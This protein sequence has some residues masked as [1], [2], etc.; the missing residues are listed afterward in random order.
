MNTKTFILVLLSMIIMFS[1]KN[2]GNSEFWTM[3]VIE[4][5]SAKVEG[6]ETSKGE[7]TFKETKVTDADGNNQEHWYYNRDGQLTTFERY[8]YKEG[9][10]YPYKSNFYNQRDS[11][12]SYY[13]FDYDDKGNKVRT[14]SHDGSTDELLR[15]EL[16]SYD[17]N[18]NR[19]GREIRTAGGQL[20]R[21][22][23]FKFDEDGNE[24][25]YKVFDGEGNELVAEAFKITKSDDKGW[26][27]KWSFRK[28][29]TSTIKTR[30]F[31]RFLP[32]EITEV[33]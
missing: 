31:A 17:D 24:K 5:Y 6:A 7:L 25:T 8:I 10:K 23:E 27:E 30:K 18:G 19:I 20:V 33:R 3:E 29:K 26:T 1:C 11:L 4:V 15:I 32:K 21:S 2:E 22:Y 28:N 14:N 16:F 13:V 9:E 12:L